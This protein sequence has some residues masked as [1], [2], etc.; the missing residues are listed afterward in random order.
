MSYI[1]FPGLGIEPFHIDKIAFTIFGRSVAWYGVLI[2]IGMILAICIAFKCAKFEKIKSD[3]IIDLALFAIIF[4]VLGS[5]L[6]YV[7]FTWNEFDYLVTSGSF[8][9]NLWNTFVNVIAIWN[10]G[11]A[12]Y[13]G[14]IGGILVAVVFSKVKKIKFT[15]II[16]ILAPCV[17][18]GQIIGRWGNFVN[19]EAYGGETALP[20][21][22]GLLFGDAATGQWFSEQYVHPTFFYESCWNLIGLI[23]ILS[24]YKK[25]KFDG[26][27]AAMYFIWYGFGRMIV[28]GLR[29][30]SLYIGSIRVS[31]LVGL[32]SVIVG[33]LMFVFL[34]QK[35]PET[36]VEEIT[37]QT[38]ESENGDAENGD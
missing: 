12:I 31:Q 3:D 10:G 23:I 30:D 33:V 22:M 7:I 9:S 37:E 38:K 6:Y 13:G 32:I 34:I 36:A 8:L 1:S 15:K 2:T 16:D 21:R 14:V 28:E 27:S 5:R 20:W 29:T 17:M 11:L 4:G 35:K 18:V 24:L 26:Q 19:M 25:K